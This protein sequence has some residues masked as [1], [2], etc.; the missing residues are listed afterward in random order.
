[1]VDFLQ[2]VHRRGDALHPRLELQR[3][4]QRVV[5][6]LVQVAAVE[7]QRF[8]LRR[9]PHVALLALPRAGSLVVSEPRPQTLPTLSAT[10]CEM[11]SAAQPFIDP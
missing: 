8:L 1:M 10:S 9:L 7:P 4:V 3:Q 2:P 5:P 6:G 11:R